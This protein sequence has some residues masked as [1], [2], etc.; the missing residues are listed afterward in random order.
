MISDVDQICPSTSSSLS[1]GCMINGAGRIVTTPPS[2][3][4]VET[5]RLRTTLAWLGSNGEIE[6][7]TA[8]G[9]DAETDGRP[10]TI[11]VMRTRTTAV[12]PTVRLTAVAATRQIGG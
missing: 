4:T 5:K 9:V 1:F 11:V 3:F 10:T 2:S 6:L 7:A 8:T 12:V